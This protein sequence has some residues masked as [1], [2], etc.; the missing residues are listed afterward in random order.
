LG[1]PTDRKKDLEGIPRAVL[2]DVGRYNEAI[3]LEPKADHIYPS[4][5]AV[6]IQVYAA[7]NVA[8]VRFNLNGGDWQPLEGGPVGRAGLIGGWW[9]GFL[10]CPG[11]RANASGSASRRWTLRS[12]R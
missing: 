4:T 12:G 1:I 7:G 8:L 5:G 9:H 2:D 11:S 6:P 3:L 10:R